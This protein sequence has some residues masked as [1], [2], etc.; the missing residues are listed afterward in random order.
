MA[1]NPTPDRANV[2]AFPP[3]LFG[4]TLVV[5]VLLRFLFPTPLLPNQT[6]LL[7][8]AAV[9]LI[10]LPIL[11]LAFR[12]MIRNKTTIHPAGTTT[13]IVSNGLYAYTRNP[14]YLALTLLYI[15]VSI[16]VNA[17]WGLLLLVPLLILVQKGIIEREEHYLTQ[18]FGDE[19]L[20]YKGQVRRWL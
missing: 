11:L 14:M 10:G 18:K 13:T 16:M 15:G 20:R 4:G 7:I 6:A 5:G 12:Q 2:I 1:I 8:G 17:Y 3:L 9:V 19:Y